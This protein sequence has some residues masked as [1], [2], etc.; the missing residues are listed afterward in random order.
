MTKAET[1]KVIA[2]LRRAGREEAAR[3]A[4]CLAELHAAGLL[5]EG[6]P[7][8]AGRK[9][10][11]ADVKAILGKHGVRGY[12]PPPGLAPPAADG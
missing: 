12:A 3:E 9:E 7:D 2:R 8:P 11:I 6:Q 4:R 1:K 10:W 5:A